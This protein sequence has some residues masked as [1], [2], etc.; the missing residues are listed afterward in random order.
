MQNLITSKLPSHIASFGT[1]KNEIMHA[2]K[3]GKY[4]LIS[5]QSDP[6]LNKPGEFVTHTATRFKEE[7]FQRIPLGS[8]F[9]LIQ[10]VYGIVVLLT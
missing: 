6:S 10:K 7:G 5:L 2:V 1:N 4:N 3:S 9:I 8:V